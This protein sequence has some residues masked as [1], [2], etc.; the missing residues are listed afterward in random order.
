MYSRPTI[1]LPTVRLVAQ[2]S[3]NDI[4][5]AML[6]GSANWGTCRTYN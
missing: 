5:S 6:L 2:T 1:K 4:I 3:R